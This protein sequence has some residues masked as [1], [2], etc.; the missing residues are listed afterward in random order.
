[1]NVTINFTS[2][3]NDA[4]TI[5]MW[6]QYF[7]DAANRT[8]GIPDNGTFYKVDNTTNGAYILVKGIN[9]PLN[10]GSVYGNADINLNVQA[11]NLSAKIQS[12]SGV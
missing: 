11:V 10:T 9:D 8:G 5:L 4:N 7:Q 6:K 2:P 3:T 1:M 12:M